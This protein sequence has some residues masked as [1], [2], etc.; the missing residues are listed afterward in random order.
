MRISQ[1]VAYD[2]NYLIAKNSEIPW[3]LP[4]DLRFF[5]ATTLQ[6]HVLMGR[7]TFETFK[8]KPLPNRTNLVLTRSENYRAEGAIVVYSFEEAIAL[9]QFNEETELFVIG[10][11]QIY[12]QSL[13]FCDRLYCTE[14]ATEITLSE[15][16]KGVYY[17]AIDKEKWRLVHE[18]YFT[19]DEKNAFAQRYC[20]YER[21]LQ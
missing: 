7:T 12:Q 16:D 2:Q 13:P 17:P 21:N 3:H 19:A 6:H 11:A 9:A 10:G 4:R 14:I 8:G 20:I 15:Q 18:H 5:K 1:I